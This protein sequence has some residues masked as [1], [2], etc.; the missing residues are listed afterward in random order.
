[1]NKLN[2]FR[3]RLMQALK[4]RKMT[5]VI[6]G[7]LTNLHPATIYRYISGDRIPSIDQVSKIADALDVDPAWLMG[8]DVQADYVLKLNEQDAVLVEKL[9]QLDPE[10][11][12]HLEFI[13]D[14]L[15]KKGKSNK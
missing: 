15:L 8:Y 4:N 14:Q 6:L 5:P 3:T 9:R 13:I 2:K 11:K 12:Q 1:M 10:D 7:Q